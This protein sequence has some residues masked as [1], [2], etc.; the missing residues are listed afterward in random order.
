MS[1]NDNDIDALLGY[2]SLAADHSCT[3]IH[4]DVAAI[5]Y[6]ALTALVEERDALLGRVAAQ[7]ADIKA[8]SAS[9]AILHG[10]LEAHQPADR[11]RDLRERLVCAALM[12][13]CSDPR[14]D[15]DAEVAVAIADRTLAAMRKGEA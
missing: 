8:L 14:Y 11:D 3:K 6:R 7:D 10:R 12:G 5:Y 1:D 9:N 4:S 2:L 13:L 15:L